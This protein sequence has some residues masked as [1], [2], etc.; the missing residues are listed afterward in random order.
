MLWELSRQ[1]D[2]MLTGSL[3]FYAETIP[4]TYEKIVNYEVTCDV[5][6]HPGSVFLTLPLQDTLDLESLRVDAAA[7][8]LL[9]QSVPY[10]I[11]REA[12]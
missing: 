1:P 10:Y 11:R 8:D 4:E 6:P 7:K 5:V 9:R 3:P 12:I 2:Q